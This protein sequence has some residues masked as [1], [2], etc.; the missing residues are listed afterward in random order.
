MWPGADASFTAFRYQGKVGVL[1]SMIFPM[2]AGQATQVHLKG[3][4]DPAEKFDN[5]IKEVFMR[6]FGWV[7]AGG[8]IT[9]APRG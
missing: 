4:I 6:V 5:L 9:P 1:L 2:S 8:Y 3:C 7:G